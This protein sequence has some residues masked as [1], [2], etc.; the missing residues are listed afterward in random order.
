MFIVSPNIV[1]EREYCRSVLLTVMS[2]G[3]ILAA[4]IMVNLFAFVC[5]FQSVS[6]VL[7]CCMALSVWRFMMCFDFEG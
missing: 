5:I 3:L 2:G 7:M 1:P 4:G 6:Y